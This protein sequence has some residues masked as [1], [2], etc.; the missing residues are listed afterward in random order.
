MGWFTV[1]HA[2]DPY[3]PHYRFYG[4][5][6]EAGDLAMWASILIFYNLLRK[7]YFALMILC[8]G[9]FFAASPSVLISLVIGAIVYT[10]K[11]RNIYY[12]IMAL[13]L[14]PALIFF[15]NSDLANFGQEILISKESSLQARYDSTFGFFSRLGSLITSYPLGIP[16][17]ATSAEARASGISFAANFT[18]ITAFDRGG[19]ICF[20]IYLILLGYGAFSSVIAIFNSNKGLLFNEISL[21]YLI[22]MPFVVQRANVFEFGIFAL[23]FSSVFLQKSKPSHLGRV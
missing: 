6:G 8:L 14:I 11:T 21:Y 1:F 15:F 23:L 9:A 16:A 5:F 3:T 20:V 2:L 18:A 4:P 19:V 13:T 10:F 22:L 17:Y 12:F 7:N